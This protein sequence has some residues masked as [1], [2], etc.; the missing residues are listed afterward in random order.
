[1]ALTV[2]LTRRIERVL[3]QLARR[4]GH[5][6][7]DLVRE[8]L[9]HDSVAHSAVGESDSAL[10]AWADVIGVIDSGQAASPR[11]SGERFTTRRAEAPRA[12]LGEA[13]VG[14]G[15]Y[16][17]QK[18]MQSGAVV[19]NGTDVPVER[20]DPM[21]NLHATITRMTKDGA[22]YPD[23]RMSRAVKFRRPTS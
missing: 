7:S 17:W 22:F 16:V 8:A 12:R 3:D 5:T 9:A 10:A 2:R 13:R 15:S 11:T 19:S 18:L 6:R 1:M 20:I 23:Q 14:E 4:R 21:P